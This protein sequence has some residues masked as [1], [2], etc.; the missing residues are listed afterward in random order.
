MGSNK[1]GSN[2]DGGRVVPPVIPPYFGG[3][4][5]KGSES[6]KS[7]LSAKT[8]SHSSV[9]SSPEGSRVG[10][11][12]GT[13]SGGSPKSARVRTL[14]VWFE[15]NALTNKNNEMRN[16]L[17][18]G[19]LALATYS[20]YSDQFMKFWQAADDKMGIG[21]T[22][23]SK[24]WGTLNYRNEDSALKGTDT[25]TKTA[26]IEYGSAYWGHL[27]VSTTIIVAKNP[28]NK[29]FNE[30]FEYTD[31]TE[32]RGNHYVTF[33]RQT[34]QSIEE[35]LASEY[36]LFKEQG[37][38]ADGVYYRIIEQSNA[39][40]GTKPE[41]YMLR[42]DPNE[43]RE[44]TLTTGRDFTVRQRATLIDSKSKRKLSDMAEI[45]TSTKLG[46]EIKTN[47]NLEDLIKK[48]PQKTIK[49]LR[50]NPD[51]EE[52]DDTPH[53]LCDRFGRPFKGD[54]DVQNMFLPATLPTM[55]FQY[56]TA[57]TCAHM[58]VELEV[59]LSM[60][61]K[62]NANN[63]FSKIIKIIETAQ[64]RLNILPD[65]AVSNMGTINLLGAAMVIKY[66]NEI[67]HGAESGSPIWPEN[68]LTTHVSDPTEH[69][70]KIVTHNEFEYLQLL[71]T[72]A[73]ILKDRVMEFN[74]VHL[75][76]AG[77]WRKDMVDL[78]L[79]RDPFEE[80]TH[81]CDN[82]T[83]AKYSVML[84]R[85]L[86]EKQL[87]VYRANHTDYEFNEYL[88]VLQYNSSLMLQRIKIKDPVEKAKLKRA[89][90]EGIDVGKAIIEKVSLCDDIEKR[91]AEIEDVA[92]NADRAALKKNLDAYMFQQERDLGRKRSRPED[93]IEAVPNPKRHRGPKTDP[94][95]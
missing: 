70:E 27:P 16:F 35:R 38:T 67:L 85:L 77:N 22:T 43:F 55:A 44:N 58:I 57:K 89:L 63:E 82:A 60:I 68:I 81:P 39:P 46:K 47:R 10:S 64:E 56:M 69:K 40:A 75:V 30:T 32:T 74:P 4:P 92:H 79:T 90:E 62:I 45:V 66:K 80:R 21:Y 36:Y 91:I 83:D 8:L 17:K 50:Y 61:K 41:Q 12:E 2:D 52:T 23:R 11:H 95:A 28:I 29:E 34:L 84:W 33:E 7:P 13:L 94:L 20:G 3:F 71:H 37:K 86:F 51:T 93:S 54:V 72:N 6:P 49:L 5:Q 78:E 1:N 65:S 31:V 76:K 87:L 14:V 59:L 42:Y 26:K 25:S 18:L 19:D 24:L 73:D 88:K 15:E 9:P 48:N 53:I